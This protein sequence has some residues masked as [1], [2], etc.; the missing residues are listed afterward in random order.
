MST[1]IFRLNSV[2]QQEADEV[3]QLLQE[4]QLEFYETTAGRWGLSV[5]GI[6]LKDE[7][8]A[9]RAKSLLKDYAQRRQQA[10]RSDY[11]RARQS[12]ELPSLWQRILAAPLHYLAVAVLAAAILYLSIWPFLF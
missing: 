4:H 5:A 11:Q 6:W 3:R 1:L 9:Q 8:Q 7:S 2:S 12:G 10:V